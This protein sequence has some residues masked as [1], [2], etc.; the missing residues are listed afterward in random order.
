MKIEKEDFNIYIILQ[1]NKN[2]SSVI[3]NLKD[4]KQAESKKIIFSKKKIYKC[5]FI[6]I[7][8]YNLRF[9]TQKF[10]GGG[11]LNI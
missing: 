1:I 9:W 10:R 7:F 3:Y 11:T 6:I 8:S 5:T 4:P 2:K